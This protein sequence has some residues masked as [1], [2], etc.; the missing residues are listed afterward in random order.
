M[1]L[2]SC[3]RPGIKILCHC[4]YDDTCPL[5]ASFVTYITLLLCLQMEQIR[6][7]NRMYTS[8]SLF[9]KSVLSIP[10]PVPVQ[11]S[12]VSPLRYD[13]HVPESV[14]VHSDHPAT[15]HPLTDKQ[16]EKGQHLQQT[17]SHP[18]HHKDHSHKQNRKEQTPEISCSPESIYL[19]MDDPCSISLMKMNGT[20]PPATGRK[21]KVI[22]T[23]NAA[24]IMPEETANDF[25]HR[26]D[27]S[28]AKTRDQVEKKVSASGV[29]YSYSEN[30][31]FSLN[32][33]GTSAASVS[34]SRS[35]RFKPSANNSAVPNG[36][37]PELPACYIRT[38]DNKVRYSMRKLEQ[39]QD[40]LFQL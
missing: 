25:L 10:V 34:R 29:S 14:V 23:E 3:S 12:P 35:A 32:Q 9:C 27:S 21:K 28:I 5:I 24:K 39:E 20:D 31:L 36:S 2:C 1:C 19:Q 22:I 17:H 8:D 11:S 4:E 33:P 16:Q 15:S 26:I 7:A 38:A 40:E 37:S 30:D 13:D 6:R 18:H